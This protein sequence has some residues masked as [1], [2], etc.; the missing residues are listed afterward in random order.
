MMHGGYGC[1]TGCCGH[2]VEVDGE[3]I[4]QFE[5]GHPGRDEDFRKWAEA[6]IEEVYPGHSGDL[7]WENSRVSED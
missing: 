1:D 2:W 3:R 6:L 5:F 4:G 7:D